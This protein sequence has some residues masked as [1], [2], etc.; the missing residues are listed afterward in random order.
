MMEKPSTQVFGWCLFS[1]FKLTFM[2]VSLHSA[3][4]TERSCR[5]W[6]GCNRPDS[7]LCHLVSG[8][9]VIHCHGRKSL[10]TLYQKLLVTKFLDV[11]W[12]MVKREYHMSLPCIWKAF[13]SHNHKQ[14]F[15]CWGNLIV[16]H[17]VL[18]IYKISKRD[19]ENPGFFIYRDCPAVTEGEILEIMNTKG[20]SFKKPK[21][22]NV[23]VPAGMLK[24][25]VHLLD[26]SVFSVETLDCIYGA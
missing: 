18:S 25:A 9:L 17:F 13:I 1:C 24:L 20:S 19:F 6:P 8:R 16:R 21:D 2:L 12:R 14:D 15:I 7:F 26:Y 23:Q 5:R 3:G 11:M 4:Q 22:W 10:L